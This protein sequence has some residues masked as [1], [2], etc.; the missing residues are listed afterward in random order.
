[1]E[2]EKEQTERETRTNTEKWKTVSLRCIFQQINNGVPRVG[3]QNVL[4]ILMELGR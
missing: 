3:V 2:R 1:M 4:A